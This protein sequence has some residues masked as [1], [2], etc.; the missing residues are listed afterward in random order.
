MFRHL[1]ARRGELVAAYGADWEKESSK[2]LSRDFFLVLAA[3]QMTAK[4]EI[5]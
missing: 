5:P 2:R 4:V 3:Q 1:T